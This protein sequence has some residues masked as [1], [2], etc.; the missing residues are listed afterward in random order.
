MLKVAKLLHMELDS[1]FPYFKIQYVLH[2]VRKNNV[3]VID[4]H[5]IHF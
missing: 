5:W 2:A 4:K 1:P 3:S